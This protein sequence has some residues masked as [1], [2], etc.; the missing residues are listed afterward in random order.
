MPHL[1]RL[2]PALYRHRRPVVFGLLAL[3]A[4]TVLSVAGPWVLRHAVDD[5]T[6]AV[7]RAK[8]WLYAGAILA[9]VTAEGFFRYRMRMVLIGI[10]REMEYELRNRV[11]HH[12]TLLSARYYQHNRNGEL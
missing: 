12:L 7:T 4:T 3:L 2:L 8:L 11:F 1:R 10:S 5:L 9:L 6:V